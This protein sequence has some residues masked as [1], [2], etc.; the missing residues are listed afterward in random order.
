M[1]IKNFSG[2]LNLRMSKHLHRELAKEAALQG[3]SL[4]DLINAKLEH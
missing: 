1:T 2:K 3:V 4:N